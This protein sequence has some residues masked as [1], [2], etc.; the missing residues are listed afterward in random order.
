MAGYYDRWRSQGGI[1]RVPRGDDHRGNIHVGGTVVSTELTTRDQEICR[2]VGHRLKRDG[3]SFV[4]LDIIG[5]FLTEVNVTSPTGIREYY[6][7]TGTDLG[8]TFL[9][10]LESA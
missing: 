7:L 8:E 2:Q 5:E 10:F 6:E 4:G 3:L 9:D 1:L